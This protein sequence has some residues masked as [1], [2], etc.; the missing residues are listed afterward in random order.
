MEIPNVIKLR[1]LLTVNKTEFKKFYWFEMKGN[2]FYWGSAYRSAR[3]DKASTKFN[4]PKAII[5]IP[6][7]LHLLPRLN[8]KYSYHQSGTTHYKKQLENGISVYQEHS[9][10]CL[11]VDIKKPVMFYGLFS[12]VLKY[13]DKS[14]F[15]PSKDCAFALAI[16]FKPENME[17]R[18]YFE[19]FLSPEGTFKSPEPLIKIDKQ[20]T[21]F[22]THTIS[23]D[24]I[25]V[26]RFAVMSNLANWHPDKEIVFMLDE[27]K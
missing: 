10:W 7:D 16:N 13:Y 22:I 2:D 14:I 15:N 4:G 18:I 26:I 21:E 25:L 27:L 6:E 8:G 12:R 9:K 1:L 5:T 17:N 3:S 23:K 19:F 20:I 11:K 24:L